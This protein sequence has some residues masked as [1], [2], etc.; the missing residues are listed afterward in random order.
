MD[1]ENIGFSTEKRCSGNVLWAR[2]GYMMCGGLRLFPI[3]IHVLV[4]AELKSGGIIFYRSQT[5]QAEEDCRLS[6]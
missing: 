2:W 5:I 3:H 1:E 6:N 4:Y